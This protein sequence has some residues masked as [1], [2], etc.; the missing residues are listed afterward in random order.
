[1][2]FLKHIPQHLQKFGPII[3]DFFRPALD[4]QMADFSFED[5]PIQVVDHAAAQALNHQD[6]PRRSV[7]LRRRALAQDA[8]LNRQEY[9][10]SDTPTL[11]LVLQDQ[12]R[13][14]L[15]HWLLYVA[16]ENQPGRCYQVIGIPP[17]M[18]YWAPEKLVDIK[19][20]RSCWNIF[21]LGTDRC[22]SLKHIDN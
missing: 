8:E 19:A 9:P 6:R 21:E 13:G 15:K 5:S 3:A 4:F 14:D 11:S 22:F 16:R 12:G 1:M 18:R 10:A 20:T 17:V 2:P 7:R